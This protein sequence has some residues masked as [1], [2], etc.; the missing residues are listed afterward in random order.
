VVDLSDWRLAGVETQGMHA[1]DWLKH[2]SRERTWLYKQVRPERDRSLGEDVAEKLAC[3]FA[4][5]AGVPAARV[6]LAVRGGT[7]GCIVEDARWPGGAL[8]HG[9]VLMN[10]VDEGYDPDD[11]SNRGQSIAAVQR[12]LDRFAAPPDS[13]VPSTFHAFDVF[14]GYLVFDA[15]IA[16]VDRHD[17]NWAVLV[18]PPETPGDDALCASFDHAASLGFTL[19]DEQREMHIRDGTVDAWAR[20]GKARRFDHRAGSRWR[21]LVGLAGAA[22]GSCPAPTREHWLGR[23]LSVDRAS[24]GAVVAAAPDL[25]DVTRRFIAELVM[26]NRRRLLDVLG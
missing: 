18:R 20:G 9:R 6:E 3:E 19:S 10:E 21:T 7:R 14:A 24:V 15:L 5:L 4:S 16:Q 11:T 13:S 17:R 8:Q 22:L 1:H 2:E 23:V 26:I 12:G 25:S